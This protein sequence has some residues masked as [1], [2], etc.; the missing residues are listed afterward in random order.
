M[1]KA[2]VTAPTIDPSQFTIELTPSAFAEIFLPQK[3][4]TASETV[5]FKP[6]SDIMRMFNK[7]FTGRGK[8]ADFLNAAVRHYIG[9]SG[10]ILHSDGTLVNRAQ[11]TLT[12][13]EQQESVKDLF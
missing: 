7:F 13:E 5:S 9:A 8:R 12:F 1:S 11:S 4:T 2:S 10:C 6:D 3:H